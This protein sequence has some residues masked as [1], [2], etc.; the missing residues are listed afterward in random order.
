MSLFEEL[1]QISQK[2]KNT[3]LKKIVNLYQ[4][5]YINGKAQ[6]LGDYLR[7]C[8]C[9]F[10]VSKILGLEF[11]MDLSNHPMSQFLENHKDKNPKLNYDTISWFRNDNYQ[12]VPNSTKMKTKSCEF[13][14]ELI[15][16]LNGVNNECYS[17]FSNAFPLF[18]NVK[19]IRNGPREF[20]RNK[21]TPNAQMGKN[22]HMRLT[23]L[24]V[25]ENQYSVIHVRCGDA[26]LLEN[27]ASVQPEVFHRISN[28]IEK[29][30]PR[31]HRNKKYVLLSDN[32]QMKLLLKKRFPNLIV[33]IKE[34]THLGESN[35]YTNESIMHTLLDFYTMSTSNF[36]VSLSP[37]NWG[38]GFSEWCAITYRVPYLKIIY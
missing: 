20:I 8:Y 6:G 34:M 4:K 27:D 22:I 31:T 23:K 32:N 21:L 26:F 7:G 1:K 10:Q 24:R 3:E 12:E 13:L 38:S 17:L 29:N 15:Q 18:Q 33:Q 30:I 9:L 28:A 37:Y 5:K 35:S 36:I 16:L 11:D 25:K 14:N 2:F 19:K